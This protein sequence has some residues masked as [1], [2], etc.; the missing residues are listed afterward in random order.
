MTSSDDECEA[1]VPLS[2]R[3]EYQDVQPIHLPDGLG[4]VVEIK[5]TAKVREVLGYFR[6]VRVAKE[7]ST[8]ALELTN[9]VMACCLPA[10]LPCSHLVLAH[11]RFWCKLHSVTSVNS[12]ACKC[13][14][15]HVQLVLHI[16]LGHYVSQCQAWMLCM[17]QKPR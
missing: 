8:R 15:L 1:W 3:P 14:A 4:P 16:I 5:Y 9:E 6:A 7:V 17:S 2:Q 10:V 13:L 12:R 11:A